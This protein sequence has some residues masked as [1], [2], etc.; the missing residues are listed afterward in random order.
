MMI[1]LFLILSLFILSAILVK[2][3]TRMPGKSYSGPFLP[4]SQSEILMKDE[5]YL[6]VYQLAV[7]IGSRNILSPK[8]LAD[9]ANYIKKTLHDYGFETF[10]QSYM[11]E[12]VLC[13]NIVA[14]IKGSEKV[15]EII[16]MGAHYDSVMP[17]TPGA[18]DNGTGVAAL[19]ALAKCFSG[20]RFA[21]TLRFVFFV[22]EE[23][24]FFKTKQMGSYRYVQEM[25]E[26]KEQIK[27]MMSLETIGYYAEQKGS[28]RYPFP[29]SLFYPSSGNFIGFVGNMSSHALVAHA[30]KVFRDST[31]FPSEG[32]AIPTFF[33]GVDWS[34]QWAFWK[35][36][37]PAVMITDTAL[38]R[39]PYYHSIDDTIDKIHFEAMARVV[40]GLEKVIGSLIR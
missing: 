37:Y 14:E 12:G 25:I 20:K 31:D 21:R 32:G 26:Q 18:N 9:A 2:Y 40:I 34:D 1:N 7:Q 22:N 30:I 23:P 24:P 28:Q 39:Y 13:E 16:L 17:D 4:L 36:G 27:A 19:L 5:L 8:A 33:P 11:V 38:F 35:S 10:S 6:H 29:F 15:N 3:M